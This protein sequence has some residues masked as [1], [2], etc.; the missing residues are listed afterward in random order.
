[1]KNDAARATSLVQ[2]LMWLSFM[3]GTLVHRLRG[4]TVLQR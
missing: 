2:M 1:V 3:A 4:R